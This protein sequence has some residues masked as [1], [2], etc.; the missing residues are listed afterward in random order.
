MT[1][2]DIIG[3]LYD[4]AGAALSGFHVNITPEGL[5]PALE[6]FRVEPTPYR[7]VWAGDDA[8]A[9]VITVGLR[10]ADEAQFRTYFP[11]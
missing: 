3:T 11:A 9:P 5:T 7:R 4:D 6:A 2:I 8:M 1:E 10:F